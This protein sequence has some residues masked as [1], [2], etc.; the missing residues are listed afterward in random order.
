MSAP[1]ET[2]VDS[3][4]ASF[5]TFIQ[6]DREGYWATL[7]N[8]NR[9]FTFQMFNLKASDSS[10]MLTEDIDFKLN[11][12]SIKVSVRVLYDSTADEVFYTWMN[13][14]GG[15]KIASAQ[16]IDRLIQENK[17]MPYF[18]VE[19]LDGTPLSLDDFKGKY[20]VINWWAT[21]CG[22]CILE[23]PGLNKLVEKFESRTDVE[24]MAIA[25]D[26]KE[27]LT[28]FLSKRDFTY[29]QALFN[30]EVASIFG[31]SFP[32][33]VIVNPQG[34]VTFYIEGGNAEMHTYI[35][36]SLNRQLKIN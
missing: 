14:N 26:D 25:W 21:T 6:D 13:K 30:K 9:T 36:E 4:K 24:F 1:L 7:Y 29:Q 28:N 32:K 8:N 31:D 19:A 20:L 11:N 34:I 5:G 18:N 23:M 33:H 35:E 16:K 27:K 12:A 2:G 15:S 3:L 17:Q 10:E 22:P